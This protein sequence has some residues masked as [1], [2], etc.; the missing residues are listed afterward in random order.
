MR[1]LFIKQLPQQV[2]MVMGQSLVTTCKMR[3]D[4]CRPCFIKRLPANMEVCRGYDVEVR[5]EEH[6]ATVKNIGCMQG[7]LEM[8]G[9]S[10]TSVFKGKAR[11]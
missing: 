10:R 11:G 4:G 2:Q 1:P 3:S 5:C 7:S 9:R 8:E 6:V